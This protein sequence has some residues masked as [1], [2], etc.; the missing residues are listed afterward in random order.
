VVQG[1]LHEVG[2]GNHA[3]CFC[4]SCRAAD[5]Y[6]GDPDPGSNGITVYQTTPDKTSFEAGQDQLAVFSFGPKNLL[7]WQAGCCG[8]LL[9]NTL[10]SPKASFTALRAERVSDKAVLGPVRSRGF[11]PKENGK[12]RHEG[13]RPLIL[14]MLWR[15]LVGRITGRWKQ[16]PFF[17]V[18][19]L[20]PVAKIQVLPKGERGRLLAQN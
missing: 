2:S 1:T 14:G 15:L 12:H 6:T 13:I 19:T 9:F 11:I 18:A 8:T 4:Q 7:R 5:I 20:E 10:R 16:T 17:D 3:L